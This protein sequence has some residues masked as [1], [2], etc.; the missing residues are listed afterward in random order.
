MELLPP[1]HHR[2]AML[3]GGGK[4]DAGSGCLNI[5]SDAIP[6]DGDFI[7]QNILWRGKRRCAQSRIKQRIEEAT[8]VPGS[9]L[10]R[11]M[12]CPSSLAEHHICGT[13]HFVR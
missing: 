9:R 11:D 5:E 7:G 8:R 13:L 6:E 4:A 3:P 12:W 2:L 10:D 1:A